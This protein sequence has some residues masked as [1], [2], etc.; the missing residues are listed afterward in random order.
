[1]RV[2]FRA[3]QVVH[4]WEKEVFQQLL[5]TSVTGAEMIIIFALFAAIRLN[6]HG[7]TNEKLMALAFLSVGTIT[8]FIFKQGIEFAS[9][10]TD[11]SRDFSRMQFLQECF[12]CEQEDKVFLA[13]CKPLVIKVGETFTI[14]KESFPTISQDIILANLVNLLLTF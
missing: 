11:A 8:F 12:R 6:T 1:M 2:Y 4:D 3:A 5:P 10:V 14:T 9:K 7:A 13:S